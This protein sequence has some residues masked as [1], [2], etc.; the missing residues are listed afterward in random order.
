MI[1]DGN[2]PSK[3]NKY[4]KNYKI[5]NIINIMTCQK[6]GEN[7]GHSSLVKHFAIRSMFKIDYLLKFLLLSNLI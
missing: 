4:I 6:N 1:L 2:R 5:N 7:G 3:N